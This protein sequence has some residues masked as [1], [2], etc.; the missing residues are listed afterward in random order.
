[1]SD[2]EFKDE[3]E[4][5]AELE[6]LDLAEEIGEEEDEDKITP[7]DPEDDHESLEELAEEEEEDEEDDMELLGKDDW[8][9]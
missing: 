9:E 7:L 1:M 4:N 8:E 6:D 3:E 5:E 2:D